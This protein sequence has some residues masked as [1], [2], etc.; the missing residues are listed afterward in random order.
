[1]DY[2]QFLNE[3]RVAYSQRG[4]EM[5]YVPTNKRYA[6]EENTYVPK[7]KDQTFT[8]DKKQVKMGNNWMT[9]TYNNNKDYNK[10]FKVFDTIA[11]IAYYFAFRLSMIIGKLPEALHVRMIMSTDD[12]RHRKEYVRIHG[13]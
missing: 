10:S 13:C 6:V 4:L 8:W 2:D 7:P 1:M 12:N 3:L 5:Q 9:K 11:E